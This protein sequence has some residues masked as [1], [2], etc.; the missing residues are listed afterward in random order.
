MQIAASTNNLQLLQV[1]S[2]GLYIYHNKVLLKFESP[3]V[4]NI[5]PYGTIYGAHMGLTVKKANDQQNNHGCV[6]CY[7]VSIMTYHLKN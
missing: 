4:E 7:I 3:G 6:G 2:S 5:P 1:N